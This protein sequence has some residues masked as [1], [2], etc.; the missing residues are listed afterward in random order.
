MLNVFLAR[1]GTEGMRSQ[2]D[3]AIAAEPTGSPWRPLA[4]QSG[5]IASLAG[6]D[7]SRAERELAETVDIARAAS[8]SEEEQGALAWLALLA[9][10][11]GDWRG[12]A[13]LTDVSV[14]IMRASHLES[15]IASVATHAACARVSLHRGDVSDAK[16]SL[17]KAQLLRPLLTHS[18]PWYSVRFLL[19]LARAYVAMSDTQGA[20]AVLSQAE[21]ILRKR[22]NI[23]PVASE[24]RALREQSRVLPVAFT[25]SSGLT[26]SEL[27]VLAFLPFHLSYR[28]IAD[29]LGVKESTVKTHTVSIYG[30]F[31][32][33]TRGS[34]IE[35]ASSV[36]L[37]AGIPT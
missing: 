18:M 16:A 27:R 19:E 34:A 13:S 23:G 32:V 3:L 5:A 35:V 10:E 30:K 7:D 17:A 25:G 26:A 20:Q 11:R 29:R 36:G 33:S 15:Y 22:P 6:G 2:A 12:A 24:V 1:D 4:L 37:I 28:E 9:I 21:D 8:A 31:G 14:E